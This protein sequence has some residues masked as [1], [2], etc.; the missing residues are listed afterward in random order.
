MIFK[1]DE[2]KAI[3]YQ[4]IK[5]FED[6]IVEFKEAKRDFHFEDIG[7]YFSAISNEAN[8]KQKQY[9]WLIWSCK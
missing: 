3:L 4:L 7:K 8:L 5:S 9:G 6:E 1:S 2:L